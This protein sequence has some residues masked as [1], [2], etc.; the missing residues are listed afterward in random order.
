MWAKL[1]ES[2][3]IR[4]FS[5]GESIAIDGIISESDNFTLYPAELIEE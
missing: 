1:K 2:A 4:L 5:K 3:R